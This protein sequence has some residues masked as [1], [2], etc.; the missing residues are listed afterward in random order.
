MR[1]IFRKSVAELGVAKSTNVTLGTV[2]GVCWCVVSRGEATGRN[3]TAGSR[4]ER[5]TGHDVNGY[6]M[7]PGLYNDQ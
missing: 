2:T 4:R 7:K 6:S 1:G 3:T 5:S